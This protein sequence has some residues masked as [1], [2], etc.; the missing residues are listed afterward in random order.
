MYV[1]PIRVDL[2][3][4]FG[5]KKIGGYHLIHR[6]WEVCIAKKTQNPCLWYLPDPLLKKASKKISSFP[7]NDKGNPSANI[8]GSTAFK[9]AAHK[10]MDEQ[11]SYVGIVEDSLEFLRNRIQ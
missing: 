5:P 9:A 10:I 7:G 4:E 1:Y 6:K 3:T 2:F 11:W 8:D